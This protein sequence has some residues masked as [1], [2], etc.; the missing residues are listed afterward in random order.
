MKKILVVEDDVDIHNFIKKVLEK[1]N[2]EV[3]SA[4]LGRDI[5]LLLENNNIVLLKD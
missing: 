2:Y 5:D 1:E 3:I 4:Y